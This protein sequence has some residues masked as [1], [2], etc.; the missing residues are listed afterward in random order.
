MAIEH[1]VTDADTIQSLAY[2]YFGD[3]KR[4][5]EIAD[6][7][8]LEYPYLVTSEEGRYALHASGYLTLTRELYS[9][10]L[11]VYKGSI[12]AT[13]VNSQGV[14]RLYVAVE[15]TVIPAGAATGYIFVRCTVYGTFGNTIA[16]SIDQ[17]YKVETSLG[18]SL[19]AVK[20]DNAVAFDSGTDAT[21]KITGE[22][23]YIPTADSE[24]VQVITN[25]GSY[26]T[27]LGGEDIALAPD[28]DLAEE[29]MGDIGTFAGIDNIRQAV[30]TRLSTERGSLPH[31]PEYGTR[32]HELVG[33]A[34]A[35]YITKMMELDIHESLSYEDRIDGVSILSI[36]T[37]GTT[38]FTTLSVQINKTTDTIALQLD[39]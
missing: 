5:A 8:G 4:W 18:S 31:H 37:V 26:L 15:D 9:T 27:L 20:I 19:S 35:P 11:T 38:V 30:E 36:E 10:S 34:N 7:N 1:I 14:Q 2:T 28:G 29:S 22:P 13:K 3:A 6:Y 17:M 24:S 23:V 25:V 16:H 33:M 32:M 21:V 39:F 12:F